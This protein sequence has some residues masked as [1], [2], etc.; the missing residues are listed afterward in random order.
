MAD[1]SRE[2]SDVMIEHWHKGTTFDTL[3]EHLRPEDSA[4]GYA[5]QAHVLRLTDKPL[6][7]WKIAATSAAGQ[8]HINVTR[9]LAG[10]ILQ[11]RVTTPAE[12]VPLGYNRMKVA[13]LEFVFRMGTTLT[14]RSTPF[15]DE[16]AMGAVDGLFIGVEVPDSRFEDFTTAGAAQLIADNACGDRFVIVPEVKGDWRKTDLKAHEVR[17]WKSDGS[18]EVRTGTG[19]AVLGDPRTALTWLVNELSENEMD[20]EKGQYVTTGTCMF[21]ISVEPGDVVVG[22]Y[23]DFGRVEITLAQ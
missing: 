2:A 5:I 18:M 10:R 9:P 13:E 3:P 8:K 7:G 16:E 17:G 22:D 19:A 21:P 4:A 11:E 6:F 15:S 1:T 14:P 20:L 23:G 12:P